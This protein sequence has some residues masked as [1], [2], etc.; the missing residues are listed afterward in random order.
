MYN[1][2]IKGRFLTEFTAGG[3]KEE[4][5]RSAMDAISLHE[6]V[7]QIDLAEMELPDV[8]TAI[9][10]VRI[11]TYGSAANVCSMVRAYVDW[12]VKNN[13]FSKVN[14]K[15]LELSVDEIDAS[16]NIKRLLFK[17]ESDFVRALR[18][19]RPFDD[20]YYDVVVMIFAWIGIELDRAMNVKIG[21]VNFEQQVVILDDG[22]RSVR[23]SDELH[24]ILLTYSKTKT[25]TR[26]G[27][28]GQ[29]VVYR[30]DSFDRFIRKFCPS[31]QLGKGLTK[32][33]VISLVHDMNQIYVDLGRE[34]KFTVGNVLTSGA[35]YR[36]WCLEKSGVDIFSPKN[37]SL[38][39]DSYGLNSK[40]CE[41]LWLYKNYKRAFSL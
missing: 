4:T 37:K 33:Q 17:N 28:N 39:K 34:P 15:L 38:V 16:K 30:D 5:F 41:I 31:A 27:K 26:L 40:A 24:D 22:A 23:F 20:G 25:G 12:C 19:T 29:R 18:E 35:L 7:L 6:S 9:G 11:G 13:V 21:D 8:V 32:L 14:T 1:E 10:N 2:D 36:V 3:K